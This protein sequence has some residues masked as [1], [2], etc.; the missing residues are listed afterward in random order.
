MDWVR[1][2]KDMPSNERKVL[3][4]QYVVEG[5]FRAFKYGAVLS[6]AQ[7][8]VLVKELKGTTHELA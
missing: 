7:V 4:V 5:T 1:L 6:S 8:R 3:E 2:W